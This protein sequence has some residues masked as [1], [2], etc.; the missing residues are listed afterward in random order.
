LPPWTARGNDG[1]VE[2][3]MARQIA[4]RIHA[5]QRDRFGDPMLEHLARVAAAVPSEAQ[6]MAWLHDAI[7]RT[8]MTPDQLRA[9]G[10]TG[11][12]LEA[13]ALLSREPTESYELYA[14]RIAFAAG[15]A[16]RLARLI[17]VADL[18]DHI[19]HGTAPVGAPPYRWARRHIAA[20]LV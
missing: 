2:S 12:E 19:A 10:L 17:K 15:E 16:G 11:P 9:A 18:D 6:G 4:S 1:F 20:H 14:L 13:L 5:D 7:E 3:M 8:P